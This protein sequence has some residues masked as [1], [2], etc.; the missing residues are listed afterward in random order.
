VAE[1]IV[2]RSAKLVVFEHPNARER[3]LPIHPEPKL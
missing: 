3:L 2:A 1:V